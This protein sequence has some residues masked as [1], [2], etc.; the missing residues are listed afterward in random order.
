MAEGARWYD[1]FSN[2]YDAWL[3]RLYK[4][5]REQAFAELTLRDGHAVVDLCCGTGQ[6][7]PFLVDRGRDGP[8]VGVDTSPGMLR[9]AGLRV[10]EAGWQRVH[11]LEHDVQTLT[12]ADVHQALG[13]E[14]PVGLVVVALGLTVLPDWEQALTGAFELLA[15]GGQLLIFDAHAKKRSFQTWSVELLA[16][17]DLNRK[18]WEPLE[19]AADDFHLRWLAAPQGTF[20]GDLLVATGRRPP[21]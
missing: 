10:K 8:V 5:W 11:L 18:V 16:Q 21:R 15:P 4:P 7:L 9:R 6:N 1:L 17:A 13:E 3:E 2:V 12:L 20:G 14:L 19:R